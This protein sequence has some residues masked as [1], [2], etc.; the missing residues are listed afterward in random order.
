MQQIKAARRQQRGSVTLLMVAGMVALIACVGLALDVGIGY[1]ARAKLAAAV[2]GAALAASRAVGQGMDQAEQTKNA[3]RT[4]QAFFYSTFP[5]GTV[6]M[7]VSPPVVNVIFEPAGGARITVSAQAEGPVS[8]LRVLGFSMLPI[9][10]SAETRRNSVDLVMVTDMSSSIL[11]TPDWQHVVIDS[12]RFF[13]QLSPQVDRAAQVIYGNNPLLLVP[14]RLA[15]GFDMNE[16]RAA[17][18]KM[19][20][21]AKELEGYAGGGTATAPALAIAI[22]ALRKIPSPAL[23]QVLLLF[24]DGV[25]NRSCKKDDDTDLKCEVDDTGH[26]RAQVQMS[27]QIKQALAAGK[28]VFV[29]GFGSELTDPAQATFGKTGEQMLVD[30]LNLVRKDSATAKDP[31]LNAGLYCAAD[32]PLSL[33]RC[34][35]GYASELLRLSR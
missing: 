31:T 1:L 2:D 26:V 27:K 34:F 33:Q 22:D 15:P 9:A 25:A 7:R 5:P 17:N 6:G 18:K 13:E 4:A 30:A 3:E 23:T 19:G 20:D 10:A 32:D 35:D 8:F 14:F 12:L 28:K 29:I 24:T 21:Q 11:H 16:L